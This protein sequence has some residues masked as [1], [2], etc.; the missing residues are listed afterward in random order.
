MSVYGLHAS[1]RGV[2]ARRTFLVYLAGCGLPALI[3][4]YNDERARSDVL[5][6]FVRVRVTEG[7]TGIQGQHPG[8]GKAVRRV[9]NVDCECWARGTSPDQVGI[10][11]AACDLAD[12]VQAAL[13]YPESIVILDYA[14]DQ[15]NTGAS[16]LFPTPPTRDEPRTVDGWQQIIVSVQAVWFA[17]KE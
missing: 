13:T 5:P 6:P 7:P 8:G 17:R 4:D 11:D 12:H 3:V 15:S 16:L 9:L 2:N 1:A 10:V 14:G